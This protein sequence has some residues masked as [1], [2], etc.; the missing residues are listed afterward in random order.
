MATWA[1]DTY[2]EVRFSQPTHSQRR[3]AFSQ[4]LL[5]SLSHRSWRIREADVLRRRDIPGPYGSIWGDGWKS[6]W[7]VLRREW[8]G[9]WGLLGWLLVIV[10]HSRKFPGF[11]T[12]KW[13]DDGILAPLVR[14][15]R[16]HFQAGI[17]G[18]I[19]LP[20]TRKLRRF[21]GAWFFVMSLFERGSMG[22]PM[23][24]WTSIGKRMFLRM[25]N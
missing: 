9:W 11:S 22:N 13:S 25:Y 3:R 8:M 6:D 23:I 2:S 10:V 4:V 7:C 15:F 20:S 19:N 5:G 21:L 24:L 12:S 16:S 17:Q 18:L 14:F 1:S